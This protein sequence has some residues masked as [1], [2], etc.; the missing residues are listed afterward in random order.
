MRLE[1]IGRDQE[2]RGARFQGLFA[3]SDFPDSLDVVAMDDIDELLSMLMISCASIKENS[4]MIIL[5]A[6]ICAIC[7]QN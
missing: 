3:A 5:S 7:K 2:R 6:S 4:L 1:R